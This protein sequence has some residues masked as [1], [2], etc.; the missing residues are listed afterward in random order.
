MVIEMCKK[1]YLYAYDKP[2]IKIAW[3]IIA[4]LFSSIVLFSP[5]AEFTL[6][7]RLFTAF[8]TGIFP[9][10]FVYLI[11]YWTTAGDKKASVRF[12]NLNGKI[13]EISFRDKS[14]KKFSVENV[15]SISINY[16]S[17]I[18]PL[19]WGPP[20]W[21]E[22][23]IGINA[24]DFETSQLTT[25]EFSTVVWQAAIELVKY[26]KKHEI[27]IFYNSSET[28]NYFEKISSR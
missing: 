7:E 11:L 23:S 25:V 2:S 9:L 17:H 8:L 10:L 15:S 28:E 5:A 20:R 16:T 3:T 19:S 18:F 22:V 26:A 4:V 1:L 12:I 13:F 14:L 27:K 21:S 6:K 24:L